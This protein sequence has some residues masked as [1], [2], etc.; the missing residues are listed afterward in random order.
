MDKITDILVV[1]NPLAR[2]Q[3]AVTKAALLARSLGA[4]IELLIC[5]TKS[6]RNA[7]TV[8][9]LP[10]GSNALFTNNLDLL[11]EEIAEPLRDDGI[12]VTT[13]VI[14]GDPLHE[15][16]I[17][18]MDNS[19]ADLVIKDTHHH[20]FAT[21][22][23][24]TN[25]DWHLIRACPRPLL[26]TKPTMWNARP[27]I[28]AAVDPGH[29]ND[30][31]A[32][33]D[34]RILDVAVSLAGR[35]DAPLHAMHAYFSAAIAT[36]A[37]GGMLSAIG[38]SAEALAAENALIRSRIRQITD[39][40]G[41]AGANLHVDAAAAAEYLPRMVVEYHADILVMGAIARSGLKRV[42]LGSTAERVLEGLPCDAL[43]VKSP[44]F[45]GNL[46]F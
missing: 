6:S 37:V 28:M 18:W 14:S 41:V 26:L 12:D 23:F 3:P 2:D 7:R 25:T 17:A 9:E 44:D 4:A 15:A 11:L 20:S 32:A 8:G 34:H 22:T 21:R 13:H 36:A 31:S 29:A 46:P 40:Y 38:V 1:V 16:V 24:A 10:A 43:V 33:L 42:L 35:F 45:A 39:R 5:D 19:P 30:P 27:V